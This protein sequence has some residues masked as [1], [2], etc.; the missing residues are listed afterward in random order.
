MP[1]T[2]KLRADYTEMIN[3]QLDH[4]KIDELEDFESLLK[5]LQKITQ[6]LAN[7]RGEEKYRETMIQI[8]YYLEC[9][10]EYVAEQENYS[11]YQQIIKDRISAKINEIQSLSASQRQDYIEKARV[12]KAEKE[13]KISA[14][15]ATMTSRQAPKLGDPSHALTTSFNIQQQLKSHLALVDKLLGISASAKETVNASPSS[16]LSRMINITQ[17]HRDM[18]S[19]TVDLDLEIIAINQEQLI[20]MLNIGLKIREILVDTVS[21]SLREWRNSNTYANLSE[22]T[23]ARTFSASQIPSEIQQDL[24]LYNFDRQQLLHITKPECILA[25]Q[26]GSLNLQWLAG[27]TNRQLEFVT[28]LP[29]V[30]AMRGH[31]PIFTM[32]NLSGLDGEKL[33]YITQP[34]CTTAIQEGKTTLDLLNQMN[35]GELSNAV[36]SGKYPASEE[37]LTNRM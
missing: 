11:E 16:E 36:M 8:R 20:E 13:D 24:G 27:L 37:R 2:S 1:L 6:P 22:S 15:Q 9:P 12:E 7:P 17:N 23:D 28:S 34:K 19:G 4:I 3:H 26:E 30:E 10:D 21:L 31:S 32:E 33:R 5:S 29:C 25:L 18:L 14:S 35:T